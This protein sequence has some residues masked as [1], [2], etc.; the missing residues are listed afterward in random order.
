M[1]VLILYSK[2]GRVGALAKG[3]ANALE[4]DNCSVKLMEA[5]PDGAGP[6]SGA[7]YELVIL[8]SPSLG[9][10]GGKI[11]AD[12]TATS[13]RLSRLEGRKA[14]AFVS[15]KLFGASKS[16]KA[17]MALLEKQG[18]MV[19][20]FAALGS[21]SDIDSFSKRLVRLIHR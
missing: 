21:Q 8:G 10:L 19:E 13:A 6:I 2:E 1:R 11:A 9:F 7:P 5:D 3:L 4:R 12:L 14:A 15:A 16:L 17:V 20:D 18:A